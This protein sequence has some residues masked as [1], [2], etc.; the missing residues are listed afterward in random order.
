ML[1]PNALHRAPE[2]PT[3]GWRTIGRLAGAPGL[4][5]P[6]SRVAALAARPKM[7]DRRCVTRDP[8]ARDLIR[9][10]FADVAGDAT[11]AR[12]WSRA[13]RAWPTE[14]RRELLDAY[15]SITAPTLLLWA[16]R[17]V[18]HPL[19]GAQEAVDLLPD[20]QLRVLSDTGHLITFD[21]PVGVAREIA[22]FC[23]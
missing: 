9:H 3:G 6:M 11:R 10:A 22:A 20:A 12:A 4:A 2:G 23:R 15:A 17:D 18:F 21:D 13:I 5:G 1:L 8:A 16:D 19:A 7:A 14:P